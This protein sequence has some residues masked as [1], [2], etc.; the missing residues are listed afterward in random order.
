MLSKDMKTI[1][2]IVGSLR[3]RHKFKVDLAFNLL[4]SLSEPIDDFSINSNG[5]I[6]YNNVF[7]LVGQKMQKFLLNACVQG[8]IVPIY[9][10]C[11]KVA[12]KII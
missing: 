1:N 7:N 10:S 5:T 11:T 4:N 3:V 12:I 8:Y 6:I 9:Q 2:K